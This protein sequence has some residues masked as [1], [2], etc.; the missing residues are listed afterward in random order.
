MAIFSATK[1]KSALDDPARF[2]LYR[3]LKHEREG[4]VLACLCCYP[5]HLLWRRSA[6]VSEETSG[7]CQEINRQRS[8][9]QR[10]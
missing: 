3:M 1:A 6:S 2:V 7:Y 5:W 8:L 10:R 9:W 4:D